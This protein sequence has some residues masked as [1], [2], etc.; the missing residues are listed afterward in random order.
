MLPGSG[1]HYTVIRGWLGIAGQDITQ[2]LAESF[3]LSVEKGVIVSGV[4]EGGPADQSG[5]QPGDIIT[6]IGD[7]E[8]GNSSE[9]LNYIST[10]KPGTEIEMEIWRNARR[11]E[12]DITVSERPRS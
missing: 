11:Y 8:P 10:L 7:R 12:L 3:D 4:L 2:E 6:R 5:I 1:V 9:I